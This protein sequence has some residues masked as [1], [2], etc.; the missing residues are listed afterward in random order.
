MVVF[1]RAINAPMRSALRV[2][3]ACSAWAHRAVPPLVVSG[4]AVRVWVRPPPR[5]PPS[6]LPSAAAFGRSPPPRCC[7]VAG[8]DGEEEEPTPEPVLSVNPALDFS[9][10]YRVL[11][12]YAV[13]PV[14]DPDAR[15][16]AHRAF[17]A[18]REMVGRVY[19]CA[20]GLN[21]QVSGTAEACAA[22][23][24]FA[25]AEFS[26]AGEPPL[27]FKEDP[28]AEAAFPRLRVKHKA[29]VPGE[30]VDLS[31]R[32]EDVSPQRWAAM[33]DDA[34]PEDGSER[35]SERGGGRAPVVLDIR[36]GYEWDVGRFEGAARPALDNFAEFDAS[37]YG[38]PADPAERAE[39]PVMMYCTGGI[40]CEY[41]SAKLR[42][43]GFRSVYKLQGGI[44]H[45]GNTM[46]SSE[47]AAGH[48]ADAGGAEAEAE[49][50]GTG[51]AAAV[52]VAEP[53]GA[54][55]VADADAVADAV[56]DAH[57]GHDSVEGPARHWR[58]SL[59]VFDRRN[60]VRFGREAVDGAAAAP[61]GA[62]LHCGKPTEAFFNWCVR[63]PLAP[64]MLLAHASCAH[65]ATTSSSAHPLPGPQRSHSGRVSPLPHSQWP[66]AVGLPRPR[67]RSCNIDCNQLHL[68][69][70]TC[71]ASRRGFCRAEC[72]AAPRRRPLDLLAATQ[73]DG[74]ID[75]AAAV[76]ATQGA[77]PGDADPNRLANFKPPNVPRKAY[78]ANVHLPAGGE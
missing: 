11:A 50:E 66:S 70:D 2:L 72:E 16:E 46:A 47:G 20:D 56:V 3:A 49:E 75:L 31:Q 42:S 1:H 22:Y 15:V 41:F 59:F 77:R 23:R 32:G 6:M 78:D 63:T 35:G 37:T 48:G 65:A 14:A 51:D 54:A 13:A 36:N 28:L 40:R 60:T 7:A 57:A 71:L 69:C 8:P 43:E 34:H 73:D 68:V 44:Q 45:Y 17:L 5:A 19:I 25:D 18:A 53:F 33:L 26:R 67:P 30:S 12:F 4:G 29:L 76:A 10:P 55:E 62:C 61:I 39:T 9:L 52:D 64:P 58:G 38:L 24:A 27:L 21:A 74:K